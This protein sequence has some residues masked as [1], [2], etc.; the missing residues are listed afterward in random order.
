MTHYTAVLKK[1]L[2]DNALLFDI[3]AI[4]DDM[5]TSIVV[6]FAV[7]NV[8]PDGKA[9]SFVESCDVYKQIL[10]RQCEEMAKEIMNVIQSEN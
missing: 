6:G 8:S 1:K 9:K 2:S 5:R 7:V 10:K 4:N 3:R